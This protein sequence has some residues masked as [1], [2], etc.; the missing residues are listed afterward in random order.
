MSG[1]EA[2]NIYETILRHANESNV[3]VNIF[4]SIFK[5][6]GKPANLAIIKVL[7]ETK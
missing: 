4:T 5:Y 2:S 3:S 6:L 7:A 1:R